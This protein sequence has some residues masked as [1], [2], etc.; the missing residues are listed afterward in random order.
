M[1]PSRTDYVG[2]NKDWLEFANAISA[3]TGNLYRELWIE[4][5]RANRAL[6]RR[7]GWATEELQDSHAG[8]TSVLLGAS[9]AITKQLGQLRELQQDQDFVFIGITSGLKFMLENGI[10]PKYCMIADA[11]PKMV[12][13]WKDLDMDL[14]KDT[15]LISHVCVH[16]DMLSMWKGKIKFLVIDS[17]DKEVNRKIDKWYRPINGCGNGFFALSSQYNTGAAL[18]YTVL[19]TH[20]LIFVGNELSFPDEG[21]PYYADRSDIKDSWEKQP[22]ISIFGDKVYTNYNFMCL[23]LALED[24][25]GKVPGYFF[26]ATEAGIFGVSKRYGNLPW[27]YQMNLDMAVKQARNI[28]KTGEP[29]YDVIQRPTAREIKSIGVNHVRL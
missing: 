15:T 12:R 10:V 9:P 21:A 27:I 26:N 7:C 2:S 16:P 11:D 22:H 19:R 20:V 1:Q 24:F 25:L 8:K 14:T 3:N 18:A 28:M 23:K 17:D 4:N 29:I 13:F 6:V 5:A